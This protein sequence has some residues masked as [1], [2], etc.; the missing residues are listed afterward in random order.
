MQTYAPCYPGWYCY[1]Y[2]FQIIEKNLIL[3]TRR[4][5]YHDSEEEKFLALST[6]YSIPVNEI[7]SVTKFPATDDS[8][9]IKTDGKMI[10]LNTGNKTKMMDYV[11]LD[12]NQL[13]TYDN[14]M[15]VLLNDL[16]K[17]VNYYQEVP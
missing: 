10:K 14:Q 17:I 7:T 16:Q 2:D 13:F 12:F 11:A 6:E 9:L 15:T 3:T 1:E 5:N 8:I 4:F